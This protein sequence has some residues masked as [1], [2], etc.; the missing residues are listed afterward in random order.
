MGVRDMEKTELRGLSLEEPEAQ[1]RVELLLERL[2]M[3]GNRS[4]LF[5][6]RLVTPFSFRNP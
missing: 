6:R 1:R 2:E 3:S 4:R 5:F